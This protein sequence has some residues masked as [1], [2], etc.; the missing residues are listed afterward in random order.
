MRLSP[1][2]HRIPGAVLCAVVGQPIA[3]SRSPTIH[4]LFAEQCGLALQ[5][6]RLEVAP[7]TLAEALAALRA[8]DCRGVNVTVPL[9][10]EAAALAAARA[11]AVVAAGAANTLWWEGEAVSAAN[12]DGVGLLADLVRNLGVTLR[13]RRILLLGAGGAAAGVIGPLLEAEPAELLILNRNP[14]RAE[15]LRARFADDPRLGILRPGDAT[16]AWEVIINATAAGL[17]GAG[18]ALPGGAVRPDTFCYDMG[19]GAEQTPFLRHCVTQGAR[20]VADGLGMLVEQAAAAFALWHGRAPD[21]GPVLAALR[22]AL[23]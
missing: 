6:E 10:E 17:A 20:R 3:H 5:Y 2:L 1:P 21:S 11:P 14:A 4:R 8:L 12:T 19:Y 22:T 23:G 16:G 7:G 9:K 15:S 13:G 18:P